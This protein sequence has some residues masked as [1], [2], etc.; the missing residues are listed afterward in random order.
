VTSPRSVEHAAG[1][2]VQPSVARPRWGG[3]RFQ[4]REQMIDCNTYLAR[5]SDYRDGELS[6][7]ERE[8]MEAHAE[9][10]ESCARYHRVVGRGTD[11][12]RALPELTVSDDFADRLQWRLHQADHEMREARRAAGPRQAVGT[13]AIAAAVAFAAWVPLMRSRPPV[14]RLPAVAVSA[15]RTA[16]LFS[17]RMM[18]SLHQEATGLTSRLAEIGVHVNEMPYHDIVF[19]PHGP[20]VGQLASAT[21]AVEPGVVDDLPQR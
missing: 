1:R 18:G 11:V 15:P 4:R 16:S 9:L 2:R 20:L 7:P 6:W 10:C 8:E 5:Y 19:R 21:P 12:F 3:R 13:L 14:G 17:R